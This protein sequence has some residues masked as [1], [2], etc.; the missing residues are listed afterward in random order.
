[1]D[2]RPKKIRVTLLFHGVEKSKTVSAL[3]FAQLAV[4]KDG[5]DG[6]HQV[7]HVPHDRRLAEVATEEDA[8]RIAEELQGRF[9]LIL[10]DEDRENLIGRLPSWIRTWLAECTLQKSYKE[11]PE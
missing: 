5:E 4:W 3:G 7:S 2:W 1:L 6:T 9:V 11:P 10:R 8:L